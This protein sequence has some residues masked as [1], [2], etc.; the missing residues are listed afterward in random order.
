[1]GV[2]ERLHDGLS[3]IPPADP[4]GAYER[5]VEKRI[6]RRVIRRLTNGALAMA[7]VVGSGFAFVSLSRIFDV[8]IEPAATAPNGRIAFVGYSGNQDDGTYS[9]WRMFVIDPDG[10]N[11]RE[12]SPTGVQ[13]VLYPTWSPDGRRIAFVGFLEDAPRSSVF[14]MDADGGDLQEILPIGPGE[15]IEAIHWS[16]DG[17]KIGFQLAESTP[18]SPPSGYPHRAWTIWTMSPDGTA[19][20]QVTSVGREMHFSW[21]PDGSQIVF[22]RFEEIGDLSEWGQAATDLFVVDVETGDER[23]LTDDGISRDPAWSPDGTRIAFRH[24]PRGAEDIAVVSPQGGDVT[25][26]HRPRP[27]G[28]GGGFPY[29][30]TIE[31]SPDATKIAFANRGEGDVCQILTIDVP[32]GTTRELISSPARDGCPGQ[33]GMSWAPRVVAADAL[34]PS[35]T[36]TTVMPDIGE[37]IGLAYR[38]CD[39]T[40]VRG[41]FGAS[42]TIGRAYVGTK[43]VDDACPHGPKAVTVVAIDFLGDGTA[44]VAYEGAPCDDFC[45]AFAAPDVDGDGTDELLVQ[46]VPF[47]IAGLNLYEVGVAT[48]VAADG[49]YV[50]PVTVAPPGDPGT[51]EPGEIPQLWHGGDGFNSDRLD[52][53]VSG[54]FGQVLVA[55]T[56]SQRPPESGPWV[57]HQTTFR[58]V[59]GTLEVVGVRDYESPDPFGTFGP[60]CGAK[61]PFSPG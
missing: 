43:V 26:I 39:V 46:N 24:G 23:Q 44:D 29:G 51:Y 2:D 21:S 20:R 41:R 7:V 36:P 22:E 14:L 58:L 42:D 45:T 25:T 17:T 3:R 48:E 49:P 55:S 37:D 12:I 32:S 13:E 4:G 11:A 60:I 9:G 57:V 6:R 33:Y 31:W 38:V 56:S 59:D 53:A 47:S 35:A 52:C 8:A 50:Y 27:S 28:I 18:D 34:E 15:Q 40:S 61:N 30:N 19:R 16:P 54:E 5:V 1:V 10:S